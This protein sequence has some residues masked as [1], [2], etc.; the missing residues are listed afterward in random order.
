V[1]SSATLTFNAYLNA[2]NDAYE[3][4]SDESNLIAAAYNYGVAA[5]AYYD[6]CNN[7]Q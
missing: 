3:D 2:L 6:Y 5:K 1:V 4:G 7:A